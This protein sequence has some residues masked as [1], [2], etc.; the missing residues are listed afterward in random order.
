[1]RPR[2]GTGCIS[3]RWVP[4]ANRAPVSGTKGKLLI[5]PLD[6]TGLESPSPRDSAIADGCGF[7]Y[8][9]SASPDVQL[10]VGQGIQVRVQVPGTL[11][12]THRAGAAP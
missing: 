12:L 1:M 9:L 8:L 3:K 11:A 4:S 5:Q 10:R 2:G 7:A 6:L